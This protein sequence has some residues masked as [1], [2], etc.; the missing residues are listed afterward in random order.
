MKGLT[1]TVVSVLLIAAVAALALPQRA[2]A[3]MVTVPLQDP[4]TGVGAGWNV[5]YDDDVMDFVVDAVNLCNNY[6]VL[7]VSKD[8]YLPPNP[9]TG[10][11]PAITMLF[12]QTADD[13][14]TVSRIMI[15]E[16]AISNLTG[17]DWTDFHWLLAGSDEVWFDVAASGAFGIQPVPHFQTQLW[18]EVPGAPGEAY[19]LSVVDGL[20]VSGSSYYPGVDNSDLVMMADVSEE[21]D[22]MAFTLVEVP[23]PEPGTMA[24]LGL[25]LGVLAVRRSRRRG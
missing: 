24:L 13:C 6:V 12:T 16:E 23:T 2:G 21:A 1:Q 25:G 3:D 15:A 20:V 11:F 8:F 22:P 7:E 19:A 9:D 17:A 10:E 5:T 18:S 4:N 14:S